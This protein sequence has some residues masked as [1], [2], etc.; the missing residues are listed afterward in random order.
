MRI[1]SSECLHWFGKPTAQ[2]SF[3]ALYLR[4]AWLWAGHWPNMQQSKKS[5][6]LNKKPNAQIKFAIFI[7]GLLFVIWVFYF[8]LYRWI[9]LTSIRFVSSVSWV[10]NFC[11]YDSSIIYVILPLCL[12]PW[13]L[14]DNQSPRSCHSCSC[15]VY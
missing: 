10:F 4:N 6:G 8:Q 12:P 11:S 15:S 2:V 9:K 3:H 5:T 14:V 7:F 13:A 1:T